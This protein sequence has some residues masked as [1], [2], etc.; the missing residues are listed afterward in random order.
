MTSCEYASRMNAGPSR[1]GAGLPEKR[2]TAR[3]KPPQKKWTGLHFPTKSHCDIVKTRAIWRRIR[4]QRF[5]YAGSYERWT[6]S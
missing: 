1:G 2:V 6:V 3:S 5:A 4:Q